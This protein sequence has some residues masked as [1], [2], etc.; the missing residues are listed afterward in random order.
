MLTTVMVGSVNACTVWLNCT[1]AQVAFVAFSD[2]C[3][4]SAGTSELAF[5]H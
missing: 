3:N 5:C 1:K 4:H 2:A